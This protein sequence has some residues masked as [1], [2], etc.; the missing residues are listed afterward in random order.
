MT[1]PHYGGFWIRAVASIIDS[2]L[3][4]FLLVPLLTIFY[5]VDIWA[6]EN[7]IT[8][9]LPG[10]FFWNVLVPAV[11]VILFWIWRSATPGK[12]LL[13]LKIVDAKTLGKPSKGQLL[14]RYLGYYLAI[15]TLGLSILWVA[16]DKRKQGLHDKLAGTVVVR[17]VPEIPEHWGKDA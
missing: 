5:G 10:D 15:P 3:M 12:I 9:D 13:E 8:V 16:W 2:L 1:Q 11:V 7:T 14:G 4:S 17:E 6:S